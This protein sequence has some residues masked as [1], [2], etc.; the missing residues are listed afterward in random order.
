MTV[1]HGI[2][3]V[4]FQVFLAGEASDS[5]KFQIFSLKTTLSLTRFLFYWYYD[6]SSVHSCFEA[7]SDSI[8]IPNHLP[9]F[10]SLIY[11]PLN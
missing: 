8:A 2:L 9:D 5:T 7:A 6:N 1:S 3:E 10:I 11:L 4:D